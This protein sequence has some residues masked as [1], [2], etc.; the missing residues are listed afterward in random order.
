[1][2]R[3]TLRIAGLSIPRQDFAE[4]TEEP[5]ESFYYRKGDG[6]LGLGYN[7]AA[8][9]WVVPPFYNMI[10]QGLVSEPVFAFYF[11][12]VHREGDES[13]A[14]FGG[15]NHDRYTGELIELPLRPKPVWEVEFNAFTFGDETVQL[16]STGACLDTGAS[17]IDLPV[18]LA[19][20]VYV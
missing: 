16:E 13:E 11:S 6:V 1:M 8:V 15:I 7:A 9:N 17:M 3:D 10:D 4:A 19:T 2:S 5:E 12:D 14:T 20:R 18:A